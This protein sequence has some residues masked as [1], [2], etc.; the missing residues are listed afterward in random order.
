[1]LERVPWLEL[2]SFPHHMFTL[3]GKEIWSLYKAP[4]KKEL[5]ADTQDAMVPVL[6]RIV[7]VAEA[8][9]RDVYRFCSDNSLGQKMT[10]QRVHILNEL[11]ARASGK[12]ERLRYL[13]VNS[14]PVIYY[15]EVAAG[16]LLPSSVL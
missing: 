7:V 13:C 10:Q 5:D 9:F 12:A 2:I 16:V 3:K 8:V 14:G 4:P 15:Y 1:M 6:A 11:Y